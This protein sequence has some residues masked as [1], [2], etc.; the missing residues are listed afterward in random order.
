[1]KKTYKRKKQKRKIRYDRVTILVGIVFF[2][3]FSIALIIKDHKENVSFDKQAVWI[4]YLNMDTLKDQEEDHFK[5]NF[6]MMCEKA[7]ARQIDTLIVQVRPFMDAMYKSELFFVSSYIDSDG[8]LAYDPLTQMI[9]IAHKHQLKIEAWINPYRI[10]YNEK[11]LNY[12]KQNSTIASWL[13]SDA[14]L[15]DG[16]MAMLN[17]ASEKARAY[18]IEGVKE[19]VEHYSID[20]IHFDDYFYMEALF[21]DTTQA[22]R[23]E[24]VNLL[25][26]EVYKII[27]AKNSSLTFGISPQGN[28]DNARNIGADIDTW[29]SQDGYVDY[30][31]PQI[32][33][34]DHYLEDGSLT[35]FSDRV[36]AYET[37]HTNK[38]VKLYAGLALYLAGQKVVNDAG[39][40]MY[41]DN[42]KR[43]VDILKQ[44]QWHG[45]ALFDYDSL[46]E[47]STQKELNNLMN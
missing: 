17:P 14:V 45:Y 35:M 16:S 27:K 12:F 29:L 36:N 1:M 2:V 20:G 24:N 5:A 15:I 26:K 11:Q 19:I 6:S 25:I 41:D 33:W 28:L 47:E 31:M 34:S 38:E 46:L 32:Y 10:S 23:C 13:Y 39:W 7:K 18:V 3:V 44:Q 9:D 30:V 22:T 37:L 8:I 42:L 40:T 21:N 43:Q 4:S